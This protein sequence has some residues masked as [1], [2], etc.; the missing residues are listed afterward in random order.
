MEIEVMIR[1]AA[2]SLA[3]ALLLSNVNY[4]AALT[5]M[6]SNLSLYKFRKKTTKTEV[7]VNF[8]DVVESWH[9]L[10][11]QCKTL[12][13]KEAADKLDEVFPLLNVEE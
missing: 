6:L 5:W 9:V 13:L 10:K 2:I 3:A 11:Y 4:S 7:K 12:D 8:L 1:I